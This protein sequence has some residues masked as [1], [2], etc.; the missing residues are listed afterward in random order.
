MGK[1]SQK[2]MT[3]EAFKEELEDT[4]TTLIKMTEEQLNATDA[5]T[6]FNRNS[7]IRLIKQRMPQD[8]YIVQPK[9]INIPA[10]LGPYLYKLP[11]ELRDQIFSHLLASGYPDF[12]RTSRA[13]K[14]EGKSRIFKEGVY[15]MNIGFDNG[16]NCQKP[17]QEIMATIQNVD[18]RIDNSTPDSNPDDHTELEF[19][20]LFAGPAPHRKTCHV[21]FAF[22]GKGHVVVVGNELLNR[23]GRLR[24]FEKVVLR[25]WVKWTGGATI[26]ALCNNGRD[27]PFEVRVRYCGFK[28]AW[29]HLVPHLGET[30]MISDK[31]GWIMVFYPRKVQQ[32]VPIVGSA[33]N[34]RSES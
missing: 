5:P 25:T 12:M 23:L 31:D 30:E 1:P 7:L 26:L 28:T 11:R 3:F 16:I 20:D 27:H 33:D 18:I 9:S 19:L 17:S 10:G 24:G 14:Q 32:L 29:A 4:V 8:V 22:H 2:T 15:R 13:M 6:T 21:S 34:S